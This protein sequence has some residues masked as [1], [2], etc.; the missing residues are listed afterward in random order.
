MGRKSLGTAAVD[1]V[2]SFLL[3]FNFLE[4]EL[5]IAENYVFF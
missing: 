1:P 5:E 4:F 2:D 3:F